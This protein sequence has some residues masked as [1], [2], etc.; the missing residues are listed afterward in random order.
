VPSSLAF[1]NQNL[2][3]HNTLALTITNPGTAA[4]NITGTSLSGTNSADFTPAL[5]TCSSPVSP[6]GNCSLKVTFTPSLVGAESA[7]LTVTDNAGSGTQTI[8]LTGT[9]VGIP[10]AGISSAGLA[11]GNQLQSTTSPAQTVTL[12]NSGTAALAISSISISGNFSISSNGCGSSLAQNSSCKIGITFTPQSTGALSGSLTITDNSG[13]TTGAMR[14]ISLSGTG[15]QI[16]PTLTFSVGPQTFGEAPFMVSASSN[17]SG[18]ITYSLVSGPAMVNGNT[19][20][21]IGAGSVKLEASQAASGEYLADTA[22]ATFTVSQGAQT[23]TFT[24][25][26]T[27]PEAQGGTVTVSA[28]GGGSGNPVTFTSLTTTVCTAPTSSHG[29]TTTSLIAPGTCTIA[30][31]QAGNTNYLAAHQVTMTFTVTPVIVLTVT[32]ATITTAPPGNNPVVLTLSPANGFKGSV[33]LNCTLPAGLPALAKCPGLPDT[34][35]LTGSSA[36][37]YGTGVLF[38]NGTQPATYVVTFT[39]VSGIYNDSTTATFTVK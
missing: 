12:S 20:T 17:S 3:S 37:S 8:S 23:I 27:G 36:V 32:P 25:P 5:N 11:F 2:G 10:A 34:V 4:L 24:G 21:L 14:S 15:V 39:A 13:G 1:S 33:K 6:G 18:G 26:G 9:G 38:P 16:P 35:T 28:T 7:T 29:V 22:F 31:N 19:V 30:A